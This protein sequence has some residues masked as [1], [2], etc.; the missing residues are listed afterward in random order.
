MQFSF[1]QKYQK[2]HFDVHRLVVVWSH[3]TPPP[4]IDCDPAKKKK[5]PYSFVQMIF[6]ID[7]LLQL[8]VF[9]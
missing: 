1:I 5:N 6:S 8:I 2:G 7:Q 9:D 3:Q 4:R